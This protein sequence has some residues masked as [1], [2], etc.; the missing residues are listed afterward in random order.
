MLLL[1]VVLLCYQHSYLFPDI[2]RLQNDNDA[3][4]QQ[5]MKPLPVLA[6]DSVL[7]QNTLNETEYQQVKSLFDIFQQNHLQVDGSHY[8]FSTEEKTR[9]RKLSLDIPL[10]GPWAGLRYSL[11][12]MRH[13]LVFNVDRLSVT[14]ADPDNS[15]VQIN[16]Q[17]TLML[18]SRLE[19]S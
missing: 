1:P 4:R 12:K 18:T 10:Q 19:P 15:R 14:R 3:L 6:N 13:S 11:S 9:K 16:L 2:T 5:L 8:R 7:L 17:L